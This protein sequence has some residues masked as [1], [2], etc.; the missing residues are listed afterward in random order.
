MIDK[1]QKHLD[2]I[3]YSEYELI[4]RYGD[5]RVYSFKHNYYINI[6]SVYFGKITV[7]PRVFLKMWKLL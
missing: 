4:K 3:P 1:F 6:E 2:A 7:K 5:G